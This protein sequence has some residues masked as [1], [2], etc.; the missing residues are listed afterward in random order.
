MMA[1]RVGDVMMTRT[2]FDFLTNTI[3]ILPGMKPDEL[4]IVCKQIASDLREL[5]K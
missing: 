1:I 3:E 5:V 4:R 2:M